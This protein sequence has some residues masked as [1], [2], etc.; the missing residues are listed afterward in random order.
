MTVI[1]DTV[2]AKAE[3]SVSVTPRFTYTV[4]EPLLL[5]NCI[6]YVVADVVAGE[7]KNTIEPGIE[8]AAA[9]SY[10]I[11]ACVRLPAASPTKIA[12]ESL[13][14]RGWAEN[15]PAVAPRDNPTI[16]RILLDVALGVIETD[17]PVISTND[18][19]A[20]EKVSVLGVLTTCNTEPAGNPVVVADVRI[21]P[22]L[23][24]SVSVRLVLLLGAAIVNSPVPLALPWIFTSDII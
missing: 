13:I 15:E 21:V 1:E 6:L 8:A 12:V 4:K 14:N 17:N 11:A 18:V 22:V 10:I 7:S 16:I 5:L 3:L 20:V 19:D 9:N 24:G 23:S 2:L